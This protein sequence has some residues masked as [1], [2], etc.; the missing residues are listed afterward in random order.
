M[1]IEQQRKAFDEWY[2]VKPK[3]QAE[4]IR[5]NTAWRAWLAAQQQEG[6]VIVKVEQTEKKKDVVY[7]NLN[8]YEGEEHF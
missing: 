7:E 3:G 2:G 8:C 1:N 5:Y 4:E 6:Y